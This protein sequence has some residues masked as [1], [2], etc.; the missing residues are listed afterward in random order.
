MRGCGFRRFATRRD[1]PPPCQRLPPAP[2]ARP[3]L[4][5]GRPAICQA[6]GNCY[7]EVATWSP[8]S[9][10]A[11]ST[12]HLLR[13]R[14]R[15]WAGSSGRSYLRNVSSSSATREETGGGFVQ[16][17]GTAELVDCHHVG[18]T[19]KDGGGIGVVA[20]ALTVRGVIEGCE[21]TRMAAASAAAAAAVPCTGAWPAALLKVG[22]GGG[23]RCLAPARIR[24]PAPHPPR[25]I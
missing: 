25:R 21:A 10:T 23:M 14:R 11:S 17:G 3:M 6:W 7:T 19:A 4:R 22:F 9:P 18:C 8:T 24:G 15:P 13:W 5:D 16:F 2:L 1:P 20:G 12:L